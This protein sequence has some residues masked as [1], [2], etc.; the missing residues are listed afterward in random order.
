MQSLPSGHSSRHSSPPHRPR[1]PEHS[2]VPSPE[3]RTALPAQLFPST[4]IQSLLRGQR[5][6]FRP[7]LP[8][9]TLSSQHLPLDCQK[10][11]FCGLSLL[12]MLQAR[13]S[14]PFFFFC[15]IFSRMFVQQRAWETKKVSS[16]GARA[17]KS[18]ATEDSAP[19][20]PGVPAL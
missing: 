1:L 19:L 15:M 13:H 12:H 3:A 7:S 18:P 5:R 4:S 9:H 17:G 6:Y 8:L 10:T 14:L 16:S 20:H 11:V 2:S